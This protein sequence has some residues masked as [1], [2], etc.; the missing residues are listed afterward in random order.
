M[1]SALLNMNKT[2]RALKQIVTIAFGCLCLPMVS[3]AQESFVSSEF[4]FG[5]ALGA[6]Y[7]GNGRKS[8]TEA[9]LVDGV[10]RTKESAAVGGALLVEAHCFDCQFFSREV[11]AQR[12]NSSSP[13][14]AV[15]LGGDNKVLNGIGWGWMWGFRSPQSMARSYAIDRYLELK[16][17]AEKAKEGSPERKDAETSRDEAKKTLDAT[18]SSNIK[19]T[20]LNVGVGLYHQFGVRQ[21]GDGIEIGK[22]LPSGQTDIPYRNATRTSALLIFSFSWE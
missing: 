9:Q 19:R 20:S 12:W 1:K 6:T 5:A 8:I 16:Q 2:A 15:G 13:F 18:G 7:V 10:V 11:P 17:K 14:V 22:A 4:G 3:F 21:L